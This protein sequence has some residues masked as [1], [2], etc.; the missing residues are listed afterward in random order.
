MNKTDTGNRYDI[1]PGSED[2]FCV[3]VTRPNGKVSAS[4]F[5]TIEEAH[6]W[7]ELQKRKDEEGELTI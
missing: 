2:G 5:R 3:K 7:I 6:S 4:E 1:L